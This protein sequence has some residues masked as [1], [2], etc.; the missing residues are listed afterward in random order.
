MVKL[1][2]GARATL[3]ARTKT[4]E[5][6]ESWDLFSPNVFNHHNHGPSSGVHYSF[7]T[8]ASM[9]PQNGQ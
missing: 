4:G 8:A 2:I 5:D 1:S 3:K 9:D 6:A 7:P